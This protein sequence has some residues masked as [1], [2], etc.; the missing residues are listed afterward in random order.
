MVGLRSGALRLKAW[1]LFGQWRV[2]VHGNFTAITPRNIRIGNNVAINHGVFLLGHTGITIGDN[3]VLSA[4]CM[5]VD[6]GLVLDNSTPTA[7]RAHT[8]AP[9]V[10]ENGAWIGA[11]ALILGGVTVGKNGVVGAGSVVTSD[12]PPNCVVAGNPA[13]IIRRVP[14]RDEPG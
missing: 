2:H 5:L 12:V 13:R 8:G 6:G 3:V 1:W 14:T 10:L 11:A 4:R 9:I 7:D